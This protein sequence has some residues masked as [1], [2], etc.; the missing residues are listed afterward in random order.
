MARIKIV[1]DS[2]AD[3]TREQMERYGITVV[4]LNVHFGD[5]VFK[6][7]VDIT[8]AAF[9]EK[10]QSSPVMPRTS[11]PSAGEFME[12]YNE[13]AEDADTIISLHISSHLSGTLQ[14]AEAA[15]GMVDVEVLTFDT[16]LCSQ[17]AARCAMLAAQA[18][19][20]GKTAPEIMALLEEAR[21]K[22]LL[23]FSADTLEY[24]QKNGR[25]GRAQGI[26]G[27]LLQVKPILWVDKDGFVAQYDK[28]RG[29]SKVIPRLVAAA[30]EHFP[31]GTSI[32]LSA[33]HSQAPDRAEQLTAAIS[34]VYDV[35]DSCIQTIGP[36]IGAHIGPGATG[37][38]VQPTFDL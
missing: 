25:I 17:A 7:G 12:V 28:V 2:T 38:I 8:P 26:I 16:L 34:A 14:S 13:L 1:T 23:V 22:T 19:A 31:A 9:Y 37:L 21:A 5:E 6:D 15:R 35:K 11:Q 29:K 20:A 18:A 3:I 30:E 27:S 36:V 32:N 10:L 4:P 33:I 24:L